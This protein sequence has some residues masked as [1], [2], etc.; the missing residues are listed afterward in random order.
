MRRGKKNVAKD[1]SPRYIKVA[2]LLSAGIASG[3]FPIGSQIPTELELCKQFRISRF[4]ARAAIRRL[5]EDELVVR[6]QRVGTTVVAKPGERRYK[7]SLSSLRDL[8]QYAQQTEMKVYDIRRITLGHKQARELGLVAGDSWV[9]AKGIRGDIESSRPFCITHL[10]I[11]TCFRGIAKKLR[12]RK[13][14]V[15]DLL[16]KQYGTAVERV[17][18]EFR[19]VTLD[20]DDAACL[21]AATGAPALRVIRRYY[22]ADDQLIELSDNIH[23]SDRFSYL[24]QLSR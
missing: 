7:A 17:E 18:Q 11:N 13:T 16:Q 8:L 5:V 12:K 6:R 1:A 15:Y 20:A 21:G 9:Y 19:G 10:Y 14:A 24:M 22:D 2:E 3:R 23:P 4:T